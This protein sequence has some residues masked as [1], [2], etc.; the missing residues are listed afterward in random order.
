M[1]FSEC[2]NERMVNVEV[3]YDSSDGECKG[4][5]D[6][7]S[8]GDENLGRMEFGVFFGRWFGGV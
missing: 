8:L 1:Y 4:N 2:F 7:V 5:V 3:N 6:V